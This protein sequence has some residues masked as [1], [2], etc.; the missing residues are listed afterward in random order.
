MSGDWVTKICDRVEQ[1]VNHTKSEN[2][3][4]ICVSGISPSGPIHLGNLRE[5]MTVHF[6]VEALRA[7]GRAAEHIH[8]WDDYDRLRKVPVGVDPAFAAYIGQPLSDIPDPFGEYASYGA[9]YIEQ[10][11]SSL[12]AIQVF[13]RYI[14][15]SVAYR[16]GRYTEQIKQAM[17]RRREIFD[18]LAAHQTAL[19]E[20]PAERAA[21]RAAYYPFRIYCEQCHRDTTSI[22]TYEQTNASLTYSC[23]TCHYH[24]GFSLHEKVEGKLVWKIDWPMRW[25]V[26]QADF[27]P[28]GEDH[29]APTSSFSVGKRIV[30]DVY[31]ATAPQY[32]GYAFV[33]MDG[34]TK[35]SS[36]A[37]TGATIGAGL[38]IVEP[39]ILR[40][41][42]ARRANNQAIMLDFGQGL[43]RLY[44]EW[45]AL[46]RQVRSG[47]ASPANVQAYERATHTTRGEV[48]YTPRPAPFSLLASVGDVTQG[49]VEQITRIV[50]QLSD[51]PASTSGVVDLEPR[52][53][54]A[55]N[56][57]RNYLPEDE[58]TTIRD[59]FS[60]DV[61]TQLSETQHRELSLLV[62]RL[63]SCW[64]LNALTELVYTVPKLALGL[65]VDASPDE[66]LKQAQRAFFVAIYR[67]ICGQETGPR[68]PTLLLSLGLAR[69][70]ALLSPDGQL[71]PV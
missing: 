37:G 2:A 15:Q 35:I 36:S 6:V 67:L 54:C 19:Q 53:T 34:R 44:D 69:V 20:T 46:V 24:G 56:W 65:P 40:W 42:Y 29:S 32:V 21:R 10:C 68:I 71:A 47:K 3:Q 31:G 23:Q 26:L 55:L 18:I 41:I 63:D 59:A 27:E 70:K 51:Q 1:H 39:A 38:E 43:L 16:E 25:S 62:E 28:A 12:G 61:Y 9:R 22:H 58:R 17:A 50:A 49:N 7:R 48:P 30:R 57:V 45:D 4:V 14:R 33:G 8:I 52:L 60:T 66:A 64:N 13:P 11:S 5:I